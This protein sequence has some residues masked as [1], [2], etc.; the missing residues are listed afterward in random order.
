MSS[1]YNIWIF[2]CLGVIW[3]WNK[4]INDGSRY[5]NGPKIVLLD[6]PLAALD[7]LIQDIQIYFKI[8]SAVIFIYWS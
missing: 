3:N 5:D 7:P 8:Q 4:K 1:I 6:E 2:K